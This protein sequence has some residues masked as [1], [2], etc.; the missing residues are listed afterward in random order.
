[1]QKPF[2]L[3]VPLLAPQTSNPITSS[4][5]FGLIFSRSEVGAG[6]YNN[7]TSNGYINLYTQVDTQQGF[8]GKSNTCPP[9][10]LQSNFPKYIVL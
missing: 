7:F 6:L 8:G 3:Q 10:W 5:D 4:I 2:K 9:H 1:M